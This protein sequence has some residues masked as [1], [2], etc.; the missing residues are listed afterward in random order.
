MSKKGLS[1]FFKSDPLHNILRSKAMYEKTK[2]FQLIDTPNLL[3][4][5][6]TPTLL[7]DKFGSIVIWNKALEEFS[8]IIASEIVGKGE[9]SERIRAFSGNRP[10]LIQR[11]LKNF[12][13]RNAAPPNYQGLNKYDE[14]LFV[15]NFK[16]GKYLLNQATIIVDSQN[17]IIGGLQTFEDNSD[18]VKAETLL[19]EEEYRY[20][21]L[22]HNAHDSI[23]FTDSVGNILSANAPF[24]SLFNLSLSEITSLSIYDLCSPPTKA[25]LRDIFLNKKRVHDGHFEG[26]MET[27]EG[28]QIFTAISWDFIDYIDDHFFQFFITDI[29]DRKLAEVTLQESEDRYR[30]ITENSK[31]VIW[32]SDFAFK[33]TYVSPVIE[34]LLGYTPEEFMAKP[35]GDHFSEESHFR[36]RAH[37]ANEYSFIPT[38]SEITKV[39]RMELEHFHRNGKI[40]PVELSA[41]FLRDPQGNPTGVIGITRD[42]TEKKKLEIEQNRVQKMETLELLAGGIAHDYNNL[43]TSILGN[44]ELLELENLTEDQ[45]ELCKDC[46]HASLQAKDLTE[47]LLLFAKGGFSQI[48]TVSIKTIITDSVSLLSRGV[49]SLCEIVSPDAEFLVNVDVGQINQVINNLLINANQ[50]MPNGGNITIKIE[51]VDHGNQVSTTLEDKLYVKISIQDT[52]IGIPKNLQTK[53]FNPYFTTKE[54]GHGLGLVSCFRIIQDHKGYITFDSQE[55]EGTTFYVFL[56][57]QS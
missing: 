24:K 12:D 1:K 7:T 39:I 50:A 20:S 16:D 38:S 32:T 3:Q 40:V 37:F 48:K 51:P 13:Q 28:Q 11:I 14:E 18:Q 41:T 27:K 15:P 34:D 42:I 49:K 19:A 33:M 4:S 30:I 25:I 5:L 47:Q 2:P 29:T 35:L 52:G 53:I 23:L 10:F 54:K 31:E 26:V 21:A 55:G 45:F 44:L 8:G 56:P 57:V 17:T 6:S 46:K 36:L 43:L 9:N 22:F